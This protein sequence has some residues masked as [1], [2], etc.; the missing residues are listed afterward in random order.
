MP[1]KKRCLRFYFG[2]M[3]AYGK[4]LTECVENGYKGFKPFLPESATV[5]GQAGA[6]VDSKADKGKVDEVLAS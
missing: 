5:N 3:E 2:G 4:E 1:G 6:K